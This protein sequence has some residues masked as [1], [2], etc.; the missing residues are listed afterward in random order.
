ME[1]RMGEKNRYA[2]LD[3]FRIIAA[4]LIVAIH[5]SPL[6]SVNRTA[7]FLFTYCL[8]RIAVPFFLMVTGYFILGP[9]LAAREREDNDPGQDKINFKRLL[10]NIER[11]CLLYLAATLIY[12][13]VNCYSGKLPRGIGQ[14]LK[15]IFFD[16]TFYHLW[17]LPAS[18]I[19]LAIVLC[20]F[21]RTGMKATR[22]VVFVLYLVG[23]F[24]DSYY[25]LAEQLP[26][27]KSIYSGIFI[28]SNY[29]RNGIFFAPIFLFMG[30]AIFK[31]KKRPVLEVNIIGLEISLLFMLTEG[32]LT[33][34][35][36]LQKHNSMYLFLIPVM[37]F[38]FE[39]LLRLSKKVKKHNTKQFNKLAMRIY[40]VH[41]LSIIVINNIAKILKVTGLLAK[42]TIINYLLVCILS[43]LAA[44]LIA[45]LADWR[46]FLDTIKS[47]QRKGA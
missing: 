12:L 35:Y 14:V 10:K 31:S 34:Y 22:I 39:G 9:F 26:V 23:L 29:T 44:F 15:I 30:A 7:D 36:E 4:L 18:V 8:G 47:I 13:P 1:I 19:G 41:P 37:F 42:N 43:A 21:I 25:G 46:A 38:L 16:G 6:S 33:Y 2:V 32:Y 27:I 5:T 45:G 17:Y 20:L 24:G 40:I 3:Y 11:T 28:I